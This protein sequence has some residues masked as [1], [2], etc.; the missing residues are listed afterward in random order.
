MN[1]SIL[2][3]LFLALAILHTFLA[4]HLTQLSHRFPEPSV[5]RAL[6]HLLGE[7]EVVF[8]LWAGIFILI[9]SLV[10]T[11]TAAI[12]YI[13]KLEFTEPL[14]VFVVMVICGSRPILTFA[15]KL[16]LIFSRALQEFLRIPGSLADVFCLLGLAPLLGSFITEPAAMTVVALLLRKMI[17]N[18]KLRTLYFLLAVLFVNISVGGALTPFAA[19]PILMVAQVWGWGLT[20]TLSQF[21]AKSVLVTVLNAALFVLFFRHDLKQGLR[22][23]RTLQESAGPSL[24]VEISHLVFLLLVV[25]TS[26]HPNMFMGIFLF[27][28]GLTAATRRDQE[29]LRFRESLLVAFFLGG[30]MIFGEF[31][32]WWLQP[33]LAT[34]S[35]GA[36]FLGATGLT[37]IT[38]NAALTY[39]G[40][41]V[42]GLSDSS[43][44]ALVAGALAG[45]GLTVLANAPNPAGYS[46][47]SPKFPGQAVNHLGLLAAA[48]LPTLVAVGF[49]WLF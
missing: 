16:I 27:F 7:V 26:H 24:W 17:V 25:L 6:L 46:I 18:L 40:S 21:G 32:K 30:L 49:F 10:E 42:S 34:L 37:S 23:L 33:I 8:G 22:P 15:Q 36:L 29:P 14:F 3:T 19:P 35:D 28:I 47:L 11:P 2:A 4:S 1:L 38:D 44:Y 13:E 41:Q 39:L 48:V 45:G 20:E 43:K 9:F 12:E 31:Q 5:T